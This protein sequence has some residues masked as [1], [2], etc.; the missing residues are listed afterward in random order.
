MGGGRA[1]VVATAACVLAATCWAANAIIAAGVFERGIDPGRLAEARVVVALVPL[2]IALLLTRRDLLRPPRAAIGPLIGFGISMMVVNWAYYVAI[3]RVP[4]G[5]AISL[6]YTAP[7]LLLVG[8]ALVTR[9]IP[10]GALWI[11]GALTLAGAALVS[12]ALGAAGDLDRLGLLAGVLSAISFAGYL[13]SAELAGRRGSHPV[14][15]LLIGFV[16]AVALW[17]VV[18]P[19]WDWPFGLLADPEV[20]WRVVAVGLVGTLLPFA[21][22]VAALRLVTSA[23]AG[24]ATTTEPVLAAALAWLLL[25]QSLGAA[26]LI[27]GALVVAGVLAAQLVRRSVVRVP[28]SVVEELPLTIGPDRSQHRDP[29]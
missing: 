27:G 14:S 15:S 19:M 12:G 21:L 20:A 28:D 7:V 6:Q 16:V 18:L 5:V 17:A 9:R 23:V 13:L 26:Q 10:P 29:P 3:D 2:A 25:G 24:I 4:V 1:I 22:V 8:M 11:A